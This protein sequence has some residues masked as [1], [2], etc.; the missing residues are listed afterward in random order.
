MVLPVFTTSRLI[1]REVLLS[2][3][4]CYEKHFID[5]DIISQLS[6]GVPWP[7]PKDGVR[8]FLVNQVFPHQGT[9][10]WVWGLFEKDNSAEL[11][12][13][14]DLLRDGKPENRG[15]WLGRA[16]WGKGYMTEAVVPVTDYA[17]DVLGFECLV[18]SNALGNRRSRRVKEKTGARFTG[19][20]PRR[21]VDPNLIQAEIWQI[22]KEEW[23]QHKAL[24]RG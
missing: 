20:L 19:L 4:P 11:M 22:T 3:L 13:V 23:R 18:F 24:C 14:I 1:L 10:R 9:S 2:D 5:F 7:Y 12:G 6:A 17:F 15:F 21:F 16:F 8:D